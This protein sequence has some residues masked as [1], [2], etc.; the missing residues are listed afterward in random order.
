MRPEQRHQ[1]GKL[2]LPIAI[3]T[4][5]VICIAAAVIWVKQAKASSTPSSTPSPSSTALLAPPASASA[6]RAESPEEA[7]QRYA[8]VCEK[9]VRERRFEQALELCQ[10]F[11]QVESLAAKAYASMAVASMLREGRANSEQMVSA[12]HA[13]QAAKLKDP[14]GQMIW[15]FH[16]LNGYGGNQLSS[17]QVAKLLVDAQ[18]G[19][20]DKASLLL[21]NLKQGQQCRETAKVQMFD[22]PL[23][24]MNRGEL[25]LALKGLGLREQEEKAGSER[26]VF[27]LGDLLPGAKQLSL[28]YARELPSY[29]LKPA[30]LS[31]RFSNQ[32]ALALA[33]TQQRITDGLRKKYGE[34][35]QRNAETNMPS[36][37]RTSD[38][39]EIE[40]RR[41]GPNELLL[42]YQLPSRVTALREQTLAQEQRRQEKLN[43]QTLKAI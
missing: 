27:N 21:D 37:W 24:C 7:L 35:Q 38:G 4:G 20:V 42:S 23:F 6:T 11:T 1:F 3:A 17:E 15:A 10:T 32:D 14:L 43:A 2:A 26:E 13:E 28:Q 29:L 9:A 31:Y 40:L 30:I 34:A 8:N 16:T 19:G 5:T 25:R 39:I 22:L 18:K 36:L 12:K 41:D 33:Q